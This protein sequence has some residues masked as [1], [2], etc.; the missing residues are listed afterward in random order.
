[1]FKNNTSVKFDGTNQKLFMEACREYFGNN[2]FCKDEEQICFI[3]GRFTSYVMNKWENYKEMF[4]EAPIRNHEARSI[5]FAR[6]QVQYERDLKIWN[7]SV[8]NERGAAPVPPTPVEPLSE[9]V[10]KECKPTMR[11]LRKWLEDM[12][13]DRDAVVNTENLILLAQKS[14]LHPYHRV[15]QYYHSFME[16]FNKIRVEEQPHPSQLITIFISGLKNE[17]RDYTIN[18]LT[19][20]QGRRS[21]NL[22]DLENTMIILDSIERQ[23]LQLSANTENI[24]IILGTKNPYLQPVKEVPAVNVDESIDE[25]T[26]QMQKLKIYMQ[27]G[28]HIDNWNGSRAA[29]KIIKEM[30]PK[31]L[32]E[33]PAGTHNEKETS[34]IGTIGKFPASIVG[35]NQPLSPAVASGSA[36]QI[37]R[38]PLIRR[39]SYCDGD[40]TATDR[41]HDWVGK[42]HVLIDDRANDPNWPCKL[43]MIRGRKVL[44]NNEESLPFPNRFGRGGVRGLLK[45]VIDK[46][47]TMDELRKMM[48]EALDR[49]RPNEQ[50]NNASGSSFHFEI[51]VD[52]SQ[53]EN[54]KPNDIISDS[55]SLEVDEYE[56]N[57]Y[58]PEENTD[59]TEEILLNNTSEDSNKNNIAKTDLT[60]HCAVLGSESQ[61]RFSILASDDEKLK[62]RVSLY[63]P[64]KLFTFENNGPYHL[65]VSPE[66]YVQLSIAFNDVTDMKISDEEA[67]EAWNEA[68]LDNFEDPSNVTLEDV[69]SEVRRARILAASKRKST[70]VNDIDEGVK[71]TKAKDGVIP[72]SARPEVVIP[73]IPR[74]IATPVK[75]SIKFKTPEAEDIEMREIPETKNKEEEREKKVKQPPKYRYGQKG[76]LTEIDTEKLMDRIFGEAGAITLSVDELLAL[77][78]MCQK[79]LHNTIKTWKIPTELE[80]ENLAK[81]NDITME[82]TVGIAKEIFKM[83]SN[84]DL[85][86]INRKLLESDGDTSNLPF[87]VVNM[88]KW[89]GQAITL[90]EKDKVDR[91]MQRIQNYQAVTSPRDPTFWSKDFF[92]SKNFGLVGSIAT[93]RQ[94]FSRTT[95]YS[96]F[97]SPHFK[98]C[99]F[100][101]NFII[102][103]ALI[104]TGAELVVCSYPLAMESSNNEMGIDTKI[105]MVMWDVNGGKAKMYGIIQKARI[106]PVEGFNYDQCCWIAPEMNKS[107]AALILGMPFIMKS[108]LQL[109][110]DQKG[111][112]FA[113]LLKMD[114][115]DER[116]NVRV[117][118]WDSDRNNVYRPHDGK[119]WRDDEFAKIEGEIVDIE[120]N[121]AKFVNANGY[122]NAVS[123]DFY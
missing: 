107:A 68:T 103:A 73:A 21:D 57:M 10:L 119:I 8:V 75:P 33:M 26:E 59:E 1:M 116:V 101:N 60:S 74:K 111:N 79:R 39:C 32:A 77:S 63:T 65:E 99:T 67:L 17:D 29:V 24:E 106:S 35:G 86:I 31:W 15:D 90:E 14:K 44:C 88:M 97:G 27:N 109:I 76:T 2:G 72:T 71:K 43:G 82:A 118:T 50:R 117:Q 11:K 81:K 104:D 87:A 30:K 91:T 5:R 46:Q 89:N 62:A 85:N 37:T 69:V 120:E 25:L 121:Q 49:L 123:T 4:L 95:Q 100:Q 55:S 58:E 13:K 36:Q 38:Q 115:K 94:P 19:D 110:P 12:Y 114:A 41:P 98:N 108:Q 113:R 92:K 42:C 52:W 7:S 20:G 40:M 112:M 80:L 78:P 84:E 51:G 16:M 83:F 66:H 47:L 54:I 48:S 64:F 70:E 56:Y 28:G 53:L 45:Q 93:I 9:Q 105:T 61:N 3:E 22:L 122:V 18:K 96:T 34:S 23:K 6:E 102:K